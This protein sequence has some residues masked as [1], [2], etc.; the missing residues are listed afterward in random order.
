[1]KQLGRERG[2]T[3]GTESA[4][5]EYN[6]GMEEDPI[7]I[8]EPIEEALVKILR[9]DLLASYQREKTRHREEMRAIEQA[10]KRAR[11]ILRRFFGKLRVQK[12]LELEDEYVE[13]VQ[14]EDDRFARFMTELRE[15][16]R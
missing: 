2:C 5:Q 13:H 12:E 1:M 15:T 16:I 7:P 4:S 6:R 11:H 10:R 3:E 9:P 8:S 14:E